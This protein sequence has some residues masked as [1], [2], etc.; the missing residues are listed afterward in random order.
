M[1]LKS[2]VWG[3][4]AAA[5]MVPA[6]AGDQTIDLSS[7]SASFGSTLPLL[8]GGDDKITFANLASGTYDFTVS[9]TGQFI[10]D[11]AGS[12][13]GQPLAVNGFSVFR[14]GF[15]QGQSATPLALTLTGSTFTSPLASYSVT[16]SA[17][18]AV[19]E[20]GTYALLLCGLGVVAFLARRHKG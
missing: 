14:F 5:S 18:R 1:N 2:T 9:F 19:P 20:P 3:L 16:M 12:L 10:S 7:G 6:W 15:L 13:N 17:V 8:A 4:A 11:L